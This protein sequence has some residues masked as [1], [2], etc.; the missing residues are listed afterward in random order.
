MANHDSSKKRIKQTIVRTERNKHVR[1]TVRS[2]VK[3]AR[4]AIESGDKAAASTALAD[5]I[6]RIDMA[7]SK[8]VYH[9]KTG[10]RYISRLSAQVAGL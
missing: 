1:S 7:V 9:R 2:F 6:R 8:G 5:A 10:S 4:L 3:T